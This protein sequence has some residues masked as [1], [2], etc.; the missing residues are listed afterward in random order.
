M[1]GH[2]GLETDPALLNHPDRG[3]I[4]LSP[5]RQGADE[6]KLFVLDKTD[7]DRGPARENANDDNV[8]PFSGQRH[9][10]ADRRLGADAFEHG[11]GPVRTERGF[12]SLGKILPA[13]IR[14]KVDAAIPGDGQAIVAEI[15]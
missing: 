1:P 8:R 14:R 2:Q 13:G 7:V 10:L 12:E 4:I 5:I 11:V 9:G 3:R 6:A 15:P